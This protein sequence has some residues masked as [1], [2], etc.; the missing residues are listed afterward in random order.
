M[1]PPISATIDVGPVSVLVVTR[2]ISFSRRAQ[3]S[4]SYVWEEACLHLFTGSGAH[5]EQNILPDLYTRDNA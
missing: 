1:A 4:Q 3:Q 5:V 2:E